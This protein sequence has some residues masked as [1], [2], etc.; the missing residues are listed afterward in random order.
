MICRGYL[1]VFTMDIPN[2]H[3]VPAGH[4]HGRDE[5]HRFINNPDLKAETSISTPP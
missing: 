4:E 2:Q 1:S 3:Q 5:Q